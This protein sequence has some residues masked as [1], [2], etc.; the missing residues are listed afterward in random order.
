[1]L[2]VKVEL[3]PVEVA[4]QI[5]RVGVQQLQLEVIPPYRQVGAGHQAVQ[6]RQV[7]GLAHHVAFPAGDVE[8]VEERPPGFTE[9]VEQGVAG[10]G[11]VG[12]LGVAVGDPGPV[13]LRQGCLQG[14]HGVAPGFGVVAV[15]GEGQQLS[16]VVTI[17]RPQALPLV[18]GVEVIVP[19][20]QAQP[21]LGKVDG[22]DTG[23][24]AVLVDPGAEGGAGP[25][26]RQAREQGGQF[27]VVAQPV[28]G[29]ELLGEHR[30]IAA[31]LVVAG[32]QIPVE[33]A[34]QLC[35]VILGL[36]GEGFDQGVELL[37][38]ALPQQLEGAPGGLV[39]GDLGG[40]EPAA[41][42]MGEEIVLGTDTGVAARQ[43]QPG[44]GRR[45]F[46]GAGL[47]GPGGE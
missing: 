37:Q 10:G 42:G 21:A 36:G 45:G 7:A 44:R 26:P 9:A 17:A 24:L 4:A 27:I 39:G 16:Q 1:M 29:G 12:F 32:Q 33:V 18:T 19:V 8:V 14:Q 40:F 46:G 15:V 5:G 25:E 47:P 20:R 31:R 43:F 35:V 28:D 41:V 2:A 38:G 22:V 30:E 6:L 11:V 23:I 13:V 3:G 34:D